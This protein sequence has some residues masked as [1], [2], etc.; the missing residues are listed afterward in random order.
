MS[1]PNS[2]PAPALPPA[3]AQA[4]RLS[5]YLSRMLDSQPWLA[6]A[7]AASIE[8]PLAEADLQRFV[9]AREVLH[10]GGDGALRPALRQLRIWTLCHLIVRD[11]AL[12]AP[13]AEITETMT[14]LA[15]VALR[16]AHDVLRGAL[17]E[18]YGQPL[19]PTGWEQEL[20]VVGMGKLGG[21]ELNV[22][23]DI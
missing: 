22:S 20:L 23:S 12:A 3:V 15:E 7:L 16:H 4:R 10:G 6:E 1:A 19:S 2:V 13:L 9:A 18:R 5:R 14:V 8:R 17:V 11:L 21:R